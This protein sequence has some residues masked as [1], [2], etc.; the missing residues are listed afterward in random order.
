MV[1]ETLGQSHLDKIIKE[2]MNHI[3]ML[4]RR[5]IATR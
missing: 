3:N 2:E 1:P 5:L 4:S